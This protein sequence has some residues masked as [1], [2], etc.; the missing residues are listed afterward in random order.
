MEHEPC[1]LVALDTQ[2][3]R[4]LTHDFPEVSLFRQTK[5]KVSFTFNVMDS[6]YTIYSPFICTKPFI[7]STVKISRI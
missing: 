3:A 4:N 6:S 1:G 5:G 2:V 7:V